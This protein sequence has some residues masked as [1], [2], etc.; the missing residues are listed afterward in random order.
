M[1]EQLSALRDIPGSA[2][3]SGA[4]ISPDGSRVVFAGLTEGGKGTPATTAPSSP[5][6]LTV[7]PPRC[8]GGLTCP[9]NGIVRYPTFSPD[10]TQIAFVDDYCDSS[11]NVW[12]MNA[13]G[14]DA[15][16]IVSDPL[17]AGHVYGLAWSAAGDRIALSSDVGT[18]YLRAGRL[19]LREDRQ[20]VRVLLAWSAVLSRRLSPGPAARAAGRRGPG[21]LPCRGRPRAATDCRAE[22]AYLPRSRDW[23][24]PR[25]RTSRARPPS[26]LHSPLHGV[27]AGRTR[28]SVRPSCRGSA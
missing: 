9:Q 10:G 28:A 2:R 7:A 14:S 22:P 1:T 18:L 26:L 17:G 25:C 15:H 13:D 27:L 6:T 12:V 8:C 19:G 5:S 23:P 20:C 21:I 11:H 24:E 4:T 3:P 16:Q